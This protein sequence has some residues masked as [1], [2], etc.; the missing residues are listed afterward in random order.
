VQNLYEIYE[1]I[2]HSVLLDGVDLNC[3][4]WT[5]CN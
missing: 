4:F 2:T 1:T 5:P 3:V